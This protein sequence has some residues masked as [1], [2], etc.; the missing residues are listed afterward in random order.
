MDSKIHDYGYAYLFEDPEMVRQLLETCVDEG[1]VSELVIEGL[2]P[3]NT[4]LVDKRLIRRQ[5]DV[6]LLVQLIYQRLGAAGPRF[7]P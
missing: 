5:D 1:W 4:N 6:L 3:M 7:L 2:E